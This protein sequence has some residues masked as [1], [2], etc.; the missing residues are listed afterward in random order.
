MQMSEPTFFP[1]PIAF[2]RWLQANHQKA[3]ELLVGFYRVGSGHPSITWPQSVDEALCFGWIDGVRKRIDDVSYSIRFTPR[4]RESTWS[5]VNIRKVEE[6]KSKGLMQPAGLAAYAA[7][8]ASRSAIYSYEKAPAALSPSEEKQFRRDRKAWT[9]FQSQAPSYQRV[10][11]HWVASAKRSETRVR[12]LALL[13]A[14]SSEGRK[15][16]AYSY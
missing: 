12:R 3:T 11:I 6:L 15:L 10:A 5:A 7:R 4:K 14:D 2:R 16:A 1:T 13:I 8:S 9:W